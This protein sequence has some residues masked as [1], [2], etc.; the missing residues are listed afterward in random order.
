MAVFSST[1]KDS[2]VGWRFEIEADNVA[3]LG[4]KV[5]VV[6]R[7]VAAQTMRL[8]T[9]ALPRPRHPAVAQAKFFS[10]LARAPVGRAIARAAPRVL[11]NPSLYP[12]PIL[13]GPPASMPRIETTDALGEKATLPAHDI[14]LAALQRRHDL[15]SRSGLPPV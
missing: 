7:H 13:G 11:Q 2:G 9:G 12:D 3:R 15:A 4:L 1:Q 10:Q 5:W 6:A 14:V 8:Q